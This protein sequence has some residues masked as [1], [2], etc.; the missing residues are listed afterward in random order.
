MHSSQKVKQILGL[1]MSLTGRH[2]LIVED[3]VDTGH[4]AKYLRASLM[5]Q[6]PASL[7]MATLL[8]KPDAFLGG[9]PPEHVGFEINNKFVVGYGLDY[10]QLGRE[11]GG[12]YQLKQS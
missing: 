5:E 10:A 11:F 6:N 3:I 12:I 2:A 8:Y 1:N 7:A 9:T 4:T